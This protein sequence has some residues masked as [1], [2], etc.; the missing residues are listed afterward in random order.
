[1]IRRTLSQL[2]TNFTLQLLLPHVASLGIFFS[3]QNSQSRTLS[4]FFNF[5]GWNGIFLYVDTAAGA[6][7]RAKETWN[8]IG[9][10]PRGR[11]ALPRGYT[12]RSV[13]TS[14]TKKFEHLFQHA[15]NILALVKC[16]RMWRCDWDGC[17]HVKVLDY[18][19]FAFAD[20]LTGFWT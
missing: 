10:P 8:A 7:H 13:Q 15:S 2:H 5:L 1:M 19:L 6:R 3:G 14:T 20:W 18:F 17:V 4:D 16:R 12:I 11:Q 9:Q